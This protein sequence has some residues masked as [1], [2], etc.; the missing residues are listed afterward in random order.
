[1]KIRFGLLCICLFASISIVRGDRDDPTT[2]TKNLARLEKGGK[3]W[4]FGHEVIAVYRRRDYQSVIA[5]CT[6]GLAR[7]SDPQKRAFLLVSRGG[8]RLRKSRFDAAFNDFE[9]ASHLDRMNGAAHAGRAYV[10]RTK[11]QSDAAIR[12]Y[13]TATELDPEFSIAYFNRANIY[14]SKG[15]FEKAIDDY[16]A[17]VRLNPKD[18]DGYVARGITYCYAGRRTEGL[19]DLA[20]GDALIVPGG[21]SEVALNGIAWFRATY[22]DGSLR[23]GKEA[24][25][26]ATRACQI[27]RWKEPYPLDTLAAA[28]AEIGNFNNAVIYEKRALSMSSILGT[29]RSKMETRLK[30]YQQHQPYREYKARS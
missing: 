2:L 11:G 24:V 10:Y 18:A 1:M 6:T 8:A 14:Y 7:E 30:L 23:N 12:E 15:E 17:S 13:N 5:L 29:E 26:K 22:P 28:Y 25:E 4:T 21:S 27:T 16:T 3:T 19:K 9:Q 20:K